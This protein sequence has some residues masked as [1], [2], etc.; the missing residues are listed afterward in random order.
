MLDSDAELDAAVARVTTARDGDAA[1][2]ELIQTL[3]RYKVG[4]LAC[5]S[6]VF[7]TASLDSLL[8]PYRKALEAV[9]GGGLERERLSFRQSEILKACIYGVDL[10]PQAIEL[11]KL[12]LWLTAA[13]RNEPSAD[14]SGNLFVA[15]SLQ[16]ET[17][18]GLV[19]NAGAKFDL[20]L[21]NPPWGGE[22]D[23]GEALR[24]MRDLRV[25]V[26]GALDSWEVFLA[27]AVAS[28]KPGGRFALLVP[29]TFFSAD[30]RRTRE[31]LI[32]RCRL[33][34]VY[35][36]GP[37]WFTSAVRMGT[38]VLQGVTN[39]FQK[40]HQIS[41]MVLAGNNR[42][43]AQNGRRPLTQLEAVLRQTVLQERCEQDS[44]KNI[45]VLASDWDLDLLNRINENS[46]S[47]SE[48]SEHARGDEINADGLLWRCGNCM[49]YTVPGEKAKGGNYRDKNCPR[50]DARL[51]KRDAVLEALISETRRQPYLTPYVDGRAL[52]QR[53]GKP[54]RRYMRTDLSPLFP[55][56][57]RQELFKGPKILIRQAGVGIAATLVEDDCRCPQSVYIY[58]VTPSAKASGYSNEYLLASLV[59]RTMNFIVMK[60]FAEVDPARAFAKLTHA[61]IEAL[62]I[63]KLED[64]KSR[65]VVEEITALVRSLLPMT[66]RVE[67]ATRKSNFY[68]GDHGALPLM[69]DDISMASSR[70]CRMG[71]QSLIY[72][73][74]APQLRFPPHQLARAPFRGRRQPIRL[75]LLGK[76]RLSPQ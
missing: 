40:G 28:L 36:L 44:E 52:I 23:R 34:K 10:L 18:D 38:V 73:L 67:S 14:L 20:V 51:S 17:I 24:I 16:R 13:R 69:R 5:G 76:A 47:L 66:I 26:S 68:Y 53:Y 64:A 15:D 11:A 42:I 60:R 50:C 48:V 71:K 12:A 55:T 54:L 30:K 57:K 31:W 59:S 75:R 25:P 9:A 62:P 22:F 43:N 27:L 39:R 8:V 33:E 56:L 72:F 41:T 45:Q 32:R 70:I 6:G 21:G 3:T 7:L 46:V 65:A 37:D 19:E 2:D 29:D 74:V 49:A 4:D 35:A 1:V 63:P 58:R 61:R